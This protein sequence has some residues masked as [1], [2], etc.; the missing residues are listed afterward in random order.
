[1]F[2]VLLVGAGNIGSKYLQG[3]AKVNSPIKILVVEPNIQSQKAAEK[4]WVEVSGDKSEHKINWL[5][6]LNFKHQNID[7]AIVATTALNRASVIKNV[8]L[9]AKPRYWI[10]EKIISQSICDLD[11][12]KQESEK[13]KGAWVNTPRRLM[14]WHQEFKGKFF[15]KGPL[16]LSIR[17]GF[18]GLASN[19]IH[20]IDLVS[21]WTNESLV[22]IHIDRLDKNWIK[23][24]RA[25]NFE[26]AGELLV[27]FSGGTELLLQSYPD[28]VAELILVVKLLNK[29]IWTINEGKGIAYSSNKD[30]LEGKLELQSEITG[31]MIT[32]ILTQGT[33]ELPTLQESVKHHKFF[34]NA[35]LKHWN[36]SN[37]CNDEVVPIT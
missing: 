4:S 35:M 7:L 14:K 33:C 13:S 34:L 18:W 16:R 19:S 22:S 9:R 6:N 25:D 1:M 17:G 30:I 5:N 12:I 37:H 2:N 28:S 29:D 23:S 26:V 21:W 24:K 36:L 10:I 3:L 20:F 32:K 27:K 11:L 8:S 31:P 15:E